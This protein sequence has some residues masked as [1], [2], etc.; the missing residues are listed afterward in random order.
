MEDITPN[1]DKS[2]YGNKA[3]SATDHMMVS[4]VDK[5]LSLLDE[6]DGHAAVIAALG[7]PSNLI[8]G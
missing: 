7:K 2:Q 8:T 4:L 3:G 1:I 6:T 5:V